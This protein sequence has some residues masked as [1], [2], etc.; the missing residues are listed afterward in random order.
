MASNYDTSRL[1]LGQAAAVV[2]LAAAVIAAARCG[3]D[4]TQ[5]FIPLFGIVV[6][7]GA[8]MFA[9]SYVE[10][11]HHFW[12]WATTAWFAYLGVRGFK[13]YVPFLSFFDITLTLHRGSASAGAQIFSTAALLLATR[14]VRSW[15]QT[16]Q[17]FAGEPDIVK[18]Y[19]NTSPTL[20]WSLIGATYFWVCQNLIYGLS[21]LPVWLSF[22]AATGLVL[23]AFT[24]KVAFTLE[25]APELVTEFA[26]RLLELNFTKGAPLVTRALTVFIGIGLFAALTVIFMLARRRIS[27]GQSGK[28][29]LR[30]FSPP[31]G[32]FPHQP[33]SSSPLAPPYY[34][35]P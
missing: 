20:L 31:P 30:L 12:Y 22:S 8:M 16:G 11:E 15:N 23:S 33:L 35:H 24:F 34:H 3:S 27:V 19:L 18:L 32:V 7:Y 14:L 17:K 26:R 21:G 2:A 1:F 4:T 25:D 5:S 13:R 28:P 10:E 9:S 29:S 6:A